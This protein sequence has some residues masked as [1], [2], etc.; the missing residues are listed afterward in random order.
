MDSVHKYEPPEAY[1]GEYFA[2]MKSLAGSYVFT[3]KDEGRK[4]AKSVKNDAEALE[5]GIGFEKDS[6][7]F[8][9]KTKTVVPEY[10]LKIIDELIS[11][12]QDH[13]RKLTDLKKE[14]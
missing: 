9:T 13:L 6:I 7:L 11:Q 3:K 1:P 2:Y 5:M 14:V 12:E 10:D 4:I 8:Y